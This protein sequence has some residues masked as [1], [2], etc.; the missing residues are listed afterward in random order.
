MHENRKKTKKKSNIIMVIMTS[1]IQTTFYL[2]TIFLPLTFTTINNELFEFPK[3]I[4]LLLG[5][6]AI[7]LAWL[8]DFFTQPASQSGKRLEARGLRLT[9]ASLLAFV[10]S[11][12]LSTIFSIH[13]YTSFWGYYTRFHQG[14]LTTICYTIL[15]FAYLKYMD[16]KATQKLIKLSI[17]TASI[18]SVYAILE[19]LGIDKNLW[20]QDVV[21]R[22]FATLGQPNWLAAYLLPNFYFNLHL[23]Q[24]KG[25]RLKAKGFLLVARHLSLVAIISG[26]LLTK[27][28]SAYLALTLTLP[29]YFLI[30]IIHQLKQKTKPNLKPLLY[31]ISYTLLA[32]TLFGTPWTQPIYKYFHPNHQPSTMNHELRPQT[33]GTQLA[34][35]GGTESGKIREIVWRGAWNLFKQHP[36][37][38]TGVETFAYTYYWVRPVTH[39]YV[40]E[41]DFLYN[42]AHNEYL[43]FL[44]NS[45][46]LGLLTYLAFPLIFLLSPVTSRLPA[47]AGWSLSI[48]IALLAIL[49]DNFFGFSVIPV[50]YFFYLLPTIAF[51][52]SKENPKPKTYDLQPKTYNLK[53]TTYTLYAI[54]YTLYAIFIITHLFIPDLNYTKAKKL[55]RL[56]KYPQAIPYFQKAI[57]KRPKMALYHT[58]YA[59]DLAKLTLLLAQNKNYKTQAP[60]FEQLTLEQLALSKKLNPWH[61]NFYKS[62]T[63]A[64]IDLAQLRPNYY[65]LAAQEIEQ[66]RKLAPTDPKLAYNLG[67]IYSRMNQNQKAIDQMK[68]AIKLKK[69]YY[70]PY[71][72]LVLLYEETNQKDLIPPLLKQAQQNLPFIPKPPQKKINQYL[73]Q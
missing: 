5:T 67:L 13:P 72:A 68:D 23:I 22:P 45:G 16:K 64:L 4:I 62:R 44:A 21:N 37:L 73:S 66:A 33:T 55:F 6:G 70:D 53:P 3:F 11:Q 69:D 27:S 56:G 46:L 48:K 39:N 43:N 29:L 42:K 54:S 71:Y 17:A 41:W 18:I 60:K 30:Q 51:T 15:F 28:R 59:E 35:G 20:V 31:A 58:T 26:L 9:K 1:I 40:S 24:A 10:A 12:L 25:K 63:K 36:I 2:L 8:I 49:I 32:I 34:G 57:K 14:F 47:Q 61:L 52:L 7:A 65:Q 38:G 19:R 50:A